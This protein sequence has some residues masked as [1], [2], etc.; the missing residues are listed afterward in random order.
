MALF[1]KFWF[2]WLFILLGCPT[3]S[4][5]VPVASP[6][7]STAEPTTTKPVVFFPTITPTVVDHLVTTPILLPP[8]DSLYQGVFPGGQTGEEDDITLKDVQNYENAVGKKVT[9]VYF[10]NNWYSSRKFPMETATWI[11]DAGSIPYIRLMLR[12]ASKLDDSEPLY[13]LQNIID[14]KFDKDL[15]AWC[16]DARGFGYHLLVE[17]GTEVNSD[18]FPWSGVLNGGGVMDGYGDPTVPDGP[19]RFQDAYRHIVQ[20]CRDAGAVNITWVFHVDTQNYPDTVWNKIKFY[21]PGDDWVDWIGVSA[22]GTYTPTS[23][24]F[25]TF[26]PHMDQTYAQII[27]FAPEKPVIVAEFGSSKNNPFVD[28]VW[29]AKDALTVLTSQQYKNLIGFSWWNEAW[30]NDSNP[31]HDTTMRVQDNPDL[32]ALFQEMVGNNP[33]IIGQISQ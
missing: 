13:T 31:D 23:S 7:V 8:E 20:I 6:I 33:M 2:A 9:W 22:Y 3:P 29:W 21:Y 14:G 25:S 18:S 24:Y 15:Q 5:V 17:Y 19:E 12:S 26:Q 10:S 4:T 27:T 30:Q 1:K 16:E 28:Q 32:Q 11:H